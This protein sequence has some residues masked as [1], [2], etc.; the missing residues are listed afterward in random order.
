MIGF[1][2]K[3]QKEFKSIRKWIQKFEK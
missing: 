3:I 1:Y 2:P